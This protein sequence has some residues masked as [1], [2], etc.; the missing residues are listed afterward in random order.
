LV[1]ISGYW[2]SPFNRAGV[3]LLYW[4]FANKIGDGPRLDQPVTFSKCVVALI[5]ILIYDAPYVR[6]VNWHFFWKNFLYGKVSTYASIQYRCSTIYS[7]S[8]R[9]DF[10]STYGWYLQAVREKNTPSVTCINDVNDVHGVIFLRT[11]CTRHFML[12]WCEKFLQNRLLKNI[13]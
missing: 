6:N 12:T 7:I 9:G 5:F 13:F 3:G 8:V 10:Y 11:P 4:R 2:K 1:D